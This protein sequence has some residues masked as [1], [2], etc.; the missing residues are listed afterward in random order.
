MSEIPTNRNPSWWTSRRAE[1]AVGYAFLFPA[2]ALLGA[3]AVYPLFY[4]FGLSLSETIRGE[5][6]YI[7]ARNY[8]EA[9]GSESFWK[10][11]RVTFWYAAGTVPVTLAISLAVALALFR[12]R[13][14][15][16]FFRTAFFIPYVTSVVAGAMVWRAIFEPRSGLANAVFERVG[17]PT[18]TWLLEPRGVLHIVTGGAVAPDI[19]PSLALTCVLVFGVW[20]YCGFMIVVLLAGLAGIPRELEEAA[21]IDGASPWRVTRDVIL[22]LLTP[23]LFFLAIVGSIGALQAFSDLYAMTTDGRGPLDSTQ[24]LTVYLYT[25]FYDAG[26]LEY[27]ASVGVILAVGV[28]ALTALQWRAIS[29]RVHYE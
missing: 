22:P 9:F 10:S 29:R 21:R 17:L 14:F 23:T 1:S 19:G 16:G 3:F 25:N 27:G 5:T 24:N 12:V 20:R 2:V 8:R 6:I 18:Q 26:R 7:G 11:V 28:V 15:A 4:A 13:R